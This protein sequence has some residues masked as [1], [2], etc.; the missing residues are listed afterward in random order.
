MM[1][2]FKQFGAS[3]LLILIQQQ[4]I[5]TTYFDRDGDDDG[6]AEPAVNQAV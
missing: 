2:L 4:Q 3:G 6:R 5:T 1:L